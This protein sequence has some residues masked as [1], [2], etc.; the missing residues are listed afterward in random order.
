MANRGVLSVPHGTPVAIGGGL[1]VYGKAAYP[2]YIAPAAN[3][4]MVKSCIGIDSTN[5]FKQ[6]RQAFRA[7]IGVGLEV[8]DYDAF[9][10]K[11]DSVIVDLKDRYGVVTG[12]KCLKSHYIHEKIPSSARRFIADF[13]EKVIPHVKTVFVAH[14]IL[15]SQKTPK[16]LCYSGN[17]DMTPGEFIS[18]LQSY[19]PHVL[20]WKILETLP[21]RRDSAFML[22]HFTGSVTKAWRQIED[23]NI[24]VYPS[25]E[26]CNPLISSADLVSKYVN[27]FIHFGRMKLELG[28]VSRAFEPFGVEEARAEG[29]IPAPE[30]GAKTRLLQYFIYDLSMITPHEKRAIDVGRKLRHPVY[31]LLT[32]KKFRSEGDALRDTAYFDIVANRVCGD[33]GSM[34]AMNVDEMKNELR[35]MRDGDKIIAFGGEALELAG[36]IVNDFSGLKVEIISSRDLK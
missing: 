34:R 24:E 26:Y 32:G 16:I 25:G 14:T 11:Y 5:Y 9:A 3:P 15:N 8:E 19:Y 31:F 27:D 17:E 2:L 13:T 30:P 36:Y 28:S 1:R 35:V 10:R 29:G 20:A 6:V 7:P 22:D 23:E 4:G 33:R 12:R 18:H 21:D